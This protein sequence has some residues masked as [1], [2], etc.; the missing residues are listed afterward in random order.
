MKTARLLLTLLAALSALVLAACGQEEQEAGQLQG[1]IAQVAETEG[2]YLNV[3]E[4]KYQVQV[5]R[6]LNPGLPEDEDYLK[7]LAPADAELAD[8]EEWFAVFMRVENDTEERLR[9]ATDFEIRDTQENVYRPL[10]YGPDNDFAYR[11]GEVE[12]EELY[13]LP[14]STAGE[15]APYGS[16]LLFKVKR[17]SL[18][19]R[20][21][22]L[23]VTGAGGEKG[24]INLDV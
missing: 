2:F 22:E 16:V 21:L 9:T 20:P 13:P 6:Q 12:G 4:L 17:F 23:I 24:L 8:D 10:E 7:G 5:S 3:E 18:D 14:N 11:P 15:R 1:E 19:N